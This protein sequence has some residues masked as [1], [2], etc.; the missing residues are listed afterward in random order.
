MRAAECRRLKYSAR[1][2]SLDCLAVTRLDILD[3]LPVIKM[4]VGYKLNGEEIKQIPA[5][6]KVLGQVEPVYEEFEGWMT[7]IKVAGVEIGIV[8]VGPDREQTMVLKKL[9]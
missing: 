1:V 5:S 9:F 3:D 4:C 8:S 7:D 2:N 6:L